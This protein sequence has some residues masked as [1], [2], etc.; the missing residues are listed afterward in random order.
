MPDFSKKNNTLHHIHYH[1]QSNA[2]MV[3]FNRKGFQHYSYHTDLEEAIMVRDGI[4]MT[5]YD[6]VKSQSKKLNADYRIRS[7]ENTENTPDD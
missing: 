6:M 1:K 2:Y 7:R 4:M 5:L 3:M